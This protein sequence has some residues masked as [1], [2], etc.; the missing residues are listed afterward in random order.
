M[1]ERRLLALAARQAM[2]AQIARREAMAALAEAIVEEERTGSLA[3]RSRALLQEYRA[4]AGEDDAGALRHQISFTSALGR[5]AQQADR[6]SMDAS[7]QAAWQVTTLASAEARAT[8]IEERREQA[9]RALEAAIDRREQ[10]HAR[11]MA[12]KLQSKF[13]TPQEEAAT[14]RPAHR[15]RN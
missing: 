10:S 4:R 6:A 3:E 8:R 7:D 13:S 11:T 5:I 15:S 12:H 2:L 1:R 9:K 14:R